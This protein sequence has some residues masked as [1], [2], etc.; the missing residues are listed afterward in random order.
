MS[1]P[2]RK[3]SRFP[4]LGLFAALCG[5]LVA[6]ASAQDKGAPA[7]CAKATGVLMAQTKTGWRAIRAGDG[8]PAKTTLVSLFDTTLRSAKGGVEVRMA[9]DL[10][11]R[12][13][14]PILESAVMLHKDKE[15]DLAL[16]P[17]RGLMVLINVKKE[18]PATVKLSFHD[19][20]VEVT[21]KE[22][23]TRLALEVYSRHPPGAPHVDNATADEPVLHL[24]MIA[25]A[26][27][28]FLRHG[29]KGLTLHAPPG[30]A[31]LVWDSQLRQPDVQR[32]EELPPEVT[33]MK[34]KDLKL[35]EAAC[36]WAK[37]VPD[38]SMATILKQ[39]AA[40]KVELERNAAVIAMGALDDLPSLLGTLAAAPHADTRAHAVLAL[41]HWLGRAPGQTTK[42]DA[43]LRKAGYTEPQAHTV[44]HLLY[45][46]TQEER[47]EPRTYELL[48]S[49]LKHNRPVM[50]ELAHWHLVRLA[51]AGKSITYDALAP[52]AD[53]ERAYE[54][55]RKL[56]PAGKL[57]PVKTAA[58]MP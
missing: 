13:P 48:V 30:P 35:L 46:F 26:G 47:R 51:P 24:F 1:S 43:A 10:G 2:T 3:W 32:L 45:G 36:A 7:T 49:F 23:G 28:A 18:G 38:E 27:E 44:L 33:T 39:G 11:L 37:Q 54:E 34:E 57:P 9:A 55:W 56:I 53:R 15:H 6:P 8:V 14:L 42:L 58:P 4:Q 5:A 21:L 50:R 29:E 22:P 20:N 52:E 17:L 31:V 19:D 41:R 25:L 16:T 12:G 40:S